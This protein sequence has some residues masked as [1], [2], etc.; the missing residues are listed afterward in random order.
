MDSE[1]RRI[2]IEEELERVAKALPS[3]QYIKECSHKSYN[4]QDLNGNPQKRSILKL[5]VELPSQYT[6]WELMK[7]FMAQNGLPIMVV[8][9]YKFI[10]EGIVLSSCMS[11]GDRRGKQYYSGDDKETAIKAVKLV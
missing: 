4:N 10:H 6:H 8:N 2:E 9:P 11:L 7:K 1:T 3:M 5:E